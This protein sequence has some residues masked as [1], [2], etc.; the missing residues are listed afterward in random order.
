MSRE[1]VAD[2]SRAP[3]HLGMLSMEEWARGEECVVAVEGM[4]ASLR[5]SS[6][7]AFSQRPRK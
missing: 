4:R 5:G 2:C 3:G 7:R 6:G 1:A